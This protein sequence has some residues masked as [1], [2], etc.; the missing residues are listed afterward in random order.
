[1]PRKKVVEVGCGRNSALWLKL[2]HILKSK[3]KNILGNLQKLLI[4]CLVLPQED[5]DGFDN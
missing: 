4:M 3:N 2:A 1:M 5:S